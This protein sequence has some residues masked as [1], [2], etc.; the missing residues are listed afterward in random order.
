MINLQAGEGSARERLAKEGLD[1]G[2]FWGSLKPGTYHENRNL[3]RGSII[4]YEE[5]HHWV[6]K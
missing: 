6:Q 3:A 4:G 2:R 1:W 5:T